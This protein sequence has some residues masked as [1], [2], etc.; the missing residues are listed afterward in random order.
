MFQFV[1]IDNQKLP[2]YYSSC[3]Y[4]TISRTGLPGKFSNKRTHV[5][6]KS[7][8]PFF[9]APGNHRLLVCCQHELPISVADYQSQLP[10][11][12]F[13]RTQDKQ[14]LFCSYPP[15]PRS[16]RVVRNSLASAWYPVCCT[17]GRATAMAVPGHLVF[18]STCG[19]QLLLRS[20]FPWPLL[21]GRME[22]IRGLIYEYEA[23]KG[24]DFL[25][26][27]GIESCWRRNMNLRMRGILI[28]HD[29]DEEAGKER[30]KNKTLSVIWRKAWQR[31]QIK[32]WRRRWLGK[33]SD[34]T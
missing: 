26:Y 3:L 10:P 22:L 28:D 5:I 14:T 6:L 15:K 18:S 17:S 24:W 21:Q 4:K 32:S 13:A 12:A 1:Y 23:T 30:T 33:G 29:G 19:E 34:F 11:L 2:N 16:S 31:G 20:I 9:F 27:T 25:P 8:L 7:S